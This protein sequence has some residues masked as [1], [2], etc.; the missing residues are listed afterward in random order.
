MKTGIYEDDNFTLFCMNRHR[1]GIIIIKLLA[2]LNHMLPTII[3]QW[4]GG[5]VQQS[6]NSN[7]GEGNPGFDPL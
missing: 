7:L 4:L 2:E 5:T 3:A 6:M 1:R